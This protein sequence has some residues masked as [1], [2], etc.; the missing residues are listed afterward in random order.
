MIY[1]SGGSRRSHHAPVACVIR[2]SPDSSRR[3]AQSVASLRGTGSAAVKAT[4]FPRVKCLFYLVE[5]EAVMPNGLRYIGLSVQA[6]PRALLCE[7]EEEL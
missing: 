2:S 5:G 6:E 4:K 3:L 7:C 1:R